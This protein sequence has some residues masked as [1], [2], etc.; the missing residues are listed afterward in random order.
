MRDEKLRKAVHPAV[1]AAAQHLPDDPFLAARVIALAKEKET[2]PMKRKLPIGVIIAIALLCM[3]VT[4]LAVGLTL[5]ETWEA[6]FQKMNTHGEIWLPDDPQEGDMSLEEALGVARAAIKKTFATPDAELDAMGVYPTF[7]GNNHWDVFFSS[8]RDGNIEFNNGDHGPDGEYRVSFD[9]DTGEIFSCVWYTNDFWAAAQR[10][11]DEGDRDEVYYEY[12]R[13]DFYRQSPEQQAYFTALLKEAG[14][15]VRA[16]EEERLHLLNRVELDFIRRKPG[17]YPI[18]ADDAQC[19]AAWQAVQERC[20]FDPALL[21]KYFFQA[22]RLDAQTGTDDIILAYNW[23]ERDLML[24]LGVASGTYLEDEPSRIGTF[25]V[26]FLPGTTDVA[27]VTWLPQEEGW[28]QEKLAELDARLARES[29]AKPALVQRIGELRALYGDNWHYWPLEVQAE[30]EIVDESSRLPQEGEMSVEEA[31][32]Y[33][34]NA[35]IYRYGQDAL[36]SLGDYV[37]GVTNWLTNPDE[38]LIWE[39]YITSDPAREEDGWR[40]TFHDGSLP[41][42]EGDPDVKDM[43]DGSNG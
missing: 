23:Y 32:Q 20:G 13:A 8:R 30:L 11:W 18:A 39:I 27:A 4:A 22:G 31:T 25:M 42:P 3:S 2:A 29:K 34:L 9:G 24:T 6:S 41:P 21:Q 1:D 26:S 40:V 35:V 7:Y 10:I 16:D 36:D 38:L 43:L 19:I 17:D 14:Y 28:T 15:E 37:V 12:Q 5:R 33:A